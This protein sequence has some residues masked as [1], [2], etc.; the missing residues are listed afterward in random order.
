MN[1]KSTELNQE[2]QNGWKRA[3]I[4]LRFRIREFLGR[5]PSF[6]S[7]LAL[8]AKWAPNQVRKDTDICIEGFLRSA[9]TFAVA[10][11]VTSQTKR[12]HVA[13]HTHLAGQVIKALRLGVPTIVLIRDPR[14]AVAS[15]LIRLPH[16]SV[17]QTLDTYWRF[18]LTLL[19]YRDR[20][21]IGEFAEVTSAFGD[22]IDRLNAMSGSQF[23]R[24]EHTEESL[25]R[26]FEV[27]EEMDRVD[28]SDGAVA[29][30]HVGRPSETRRLAK[31]KVLECID[32]P[33]FASRLARCRDVYEQFLVGHRH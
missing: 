1:N 33:E 23:M 22:V 32:S 14:D 9:N 16:L 28:R 18:Y 10:A 6:I 21:V 13:R 27:V 29:E 8:A 4:Q 11:I 15:T 5:H 17:S 19:P 26:C 2:S 12:L 3:Y 24:F 20:F 30:T 31:S 25:K 7:L